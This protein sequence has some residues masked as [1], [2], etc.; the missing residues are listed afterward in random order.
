MIQQS[1]MQPHKCALSYLYRLP[2]QAVAKSTL[3]KSDVQWLSCAQ[4]SPHLN[5]RWWV[6]SANQRSLEYTHRMQFLPS[7]IFR[8][9][10]TLSCPHGL[11]VFLTLATTFYSMREQL[12]LDEVTKTPASPTS[13]L[14]GKDYL[15]KLDSLRVN[16]AHLITGTTT[17]GP[18]V[19]RMSRPRS[20]HTPTK[21]SPR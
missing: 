1:L 13:S 20:E 10:K 17:A 21:Q 14:V 9:N 2:D 19:Y 3:R 6:V 5:P 8:S 18:G 16:P 15:H 7:H 11:V 12:Y 4:T